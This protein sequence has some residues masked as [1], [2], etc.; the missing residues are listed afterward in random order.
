MELEHVKGLRELSEALKELPQ[1]IARNALRQSVAAGA[2]II[3]N[4][5]KARAPV[6]TQAPAPGDPLPGTLKRSILIKHVPERSG[7]SSQTFIVGVRSGKRYRNQ[8]KKGNRSQDAYY[9][10]W[11]EFGT[12]KM[13]A[14]PFLRPA[15]EANKQAAVDAIAQYLAK[16]IPEEVAGLRGAKR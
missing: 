9:W 1:R 3:R 12:V 15:F 8:G 10:R 5:A 14:R 13:S 16:R 6:S 11:V 4:D 2:S 7:V